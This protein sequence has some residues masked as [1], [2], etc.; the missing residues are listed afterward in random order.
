MTSPQPP[1]LEPRLPSSSDRN[2]AAAV[3]LT[4]VTVFRATDA[5]FTKAR[6]PTRGPVSEGATDAA[7]REAA[8]RKGSA[9]LSPTGS[10]TARAPSLRPEPP[11]PPPPLSEPQPLSPPPTSAVPAAPMRQASTG[12]KDGA[13]T[14]NGEACGG[15]DGRVARSRR[16][17]IDSSASSETAYSDEVVNVDETTGPYKGGNHAVVF[18]ILV[19]YLQVLS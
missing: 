17:S 12:G 11:P 19:S 4:A 15:G 5:A 10:Y 16:S 6:L 8:G 18:K 9:E 13:L 2:T 14:V 1:P 7:V 3:S